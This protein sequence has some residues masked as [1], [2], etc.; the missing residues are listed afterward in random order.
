MDGW[1]CVHC[2]LASC[3]VRTTLARGGVAAGAVCQL[4]WTTHVCYCHDRVETG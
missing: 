2:D 4:R 1:A 3:I